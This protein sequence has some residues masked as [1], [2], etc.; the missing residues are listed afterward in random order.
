MADIVYVAGLVTVRVCPDV[1]SYQFAFAEFCARRFHEA[2][3]AGPPPTITLVIVTLAQR[4]PAQSATGA[5]GTIPKPAATSTRAVGI[6]HSAAARRDPSRQTAVMGT[7]VRASAKARM[8]ERAAPPSD[9]GDMRI[10]RDPAAPSPRVRA[11]ERCSVTTNPPGVPAPPVSAVGSSVARN[12]ASPESGEDESQGAR[13][14]APYA[15]GGVLSRRRASRSAA[16][17]PPRI[18]R[19]AEDDERQ[20]RTA[21]GRRQARQ[22]HRRV[23]RVASGDRRDHRRCS[24]PRPRRS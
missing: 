22:R 23:V 4:L 15:T 3:V 16:V 17:T 7:A 9:R 20:H 21:T 13:P 2:V 18:A 11:R 10:D 1:K 6:S 12:W 8:P 5:I 19:I 24:S 14:P